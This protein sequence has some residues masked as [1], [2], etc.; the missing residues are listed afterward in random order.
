MADPY[1]LLPFRFHPISATREVLV[2]EFGDPLFC[3]RGTASRIANR[4]VNNSELLYQD[5]LANF[6][7]SE[8]A[9]PELVDVA[10]TRIRTKRASL[11]G[12]ASLHLVVLTLRCN[13][14]C[15]YCQVSRRT[16]D[17]RQSDMSLRD[18][19]LTLRLIFRS[20]SRDLTIEFQ[21]GEPLLAFD[22]VRA[23]V[24]GA[25]RLNDNHKKRLRFVLCTNLSLM[26]PQIAD[27]CKSHGILISTSLDGPAFLHDAN[28]V[29]SSG[30]SFR[31]LKAGLQV[32]REALGAD[33]VSALMTT[34]AA[35][36]EYPEAIIDAYVDNGFDHVFIRPMHPYGYAK[37]LAP[38][39]HYSTSQFVEFY[40]RCLNHIL[41]LNKSGVPLVEDYAAIILRKILTPFDVGFVDLRSPSGIVNQVVAYN[42]D[43]GVYASDESRMLA[44][45]GD[46]TFRLGH[47][48]DPYEELFFGLRVRE[49]AEHWANESLA[50]CSECGFQAYCGADPVRNHAT[51]GDLEG[52]RP[53]SDFCKKNR[54]IIRYLLETLDSD[55]A[56]ERIF[57]R[58]AA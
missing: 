12:S 55:S 27:Y 19:E 1:F 21:G 23:A 43:G 2:N 13:H 56:A 48:G 17:A 49:I 41:T 50:G 54:E 53:S 18:L 16:R 39:R 25:E 38:D 32:A 20:S 24:E 36:L 57:R 14:S 44:E 58:W 28:R 47:V 51:Q 45:A 26:S 22:K 5:L 7:I 33:M 52:H 9:I 29:M 37:R 42:Y 8:S 4:A 40:K 30:S 46:F 11:N 15:Q 10:A 3:P 6:F 34:S 35:S 31:A